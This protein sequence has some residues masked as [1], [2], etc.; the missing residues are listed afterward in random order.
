MVIATYYKILKM[1][2]GEDFDMSTDY[3]RAYRSEVVKYLKKYGLLTDKE[4]NLLY[5]KDFFTIDY[6]SDNTP[7]FSFGKARPYSYV[8][9]VYNQK[10]Q[11]IT[12]RLFKV[13]NEGSKIN[14]LTKINDVTSNDSQRIDFNGV[15][16]LFNLGIVEGDE[17]GRFNAYDYI[18]LNEFVTIVARICYPS[19][20][21]QINASEYYKKAS[22]IP[23]VQT[24]NNISS[25]WYNR[26]MELTHLKAQYCVA[27]SNSRYIS[28]EEAMFIAS[29][30]SSGELAG[31]S[32]VTIPEPVSVNSDECKKL[33]KRWNNRLVNDNLTAFS[34]YTNS[35]TTI[36]KKELAILL[37]TVSENRLV[38]F[39]DDTATIKDEFAK[40]LSEE[41]LH[42][43]TKALVL[44]LIEN[45]TKD[46]SNSPITQSEFEKIIIQ[47]AMKFST[48]VPQNNYKYG[49]DRQNLV[50]DAKLLPKNAD[51]FP[52]VLDTLPKKIY[53]DIGS[54]DPE[55]E[56][57]EG[58]G[59]YG[60]PKTAYELCGMEYS[61]SSRRIEN[62]FNVI[63][64]IDYRT[65]ELNKF[66]SKLQP[67]VAYDLNLTY[68]SGKQPYIEKIKE[69]ISYVK[70]NKIVLS[71]KCTPALP[72]VTGFGPFNVRCKIEVNVI[73]SSTNNV[74]L[75]CNYIEYIQNTDYSSIR[76]ADVATVALYDGSFSILF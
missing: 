25:S 66:V 2:N 14:N 50:T 61:T 20:R 46:F 44:G 36:T 13:I 69:Y 52:Y 22:S 67:Y 4:A 10:I 30:I 12:T 38:V 68:S 56:K 76:Y 47:F 35:K 73:S 40:G 39:T 11:V 19:R 7:A 29:K 15:L 9:Y 31:E 3:S 60:D 5:T 49:N 33:Y 64:N 6:T 62:Y 16:Q 75:C 27:Q 37:V 65:I 34:N 42:F 55:E 43:L 26:M 63:L 53:E 57:Y 24:Y 32:T 1:Y 54:F 59:I 48:F 23:K 58:S 45:T 18:S 71:G 72:Y 21:V 17:Y 41:E 51:M 28:W 8:D 74:K 70:A